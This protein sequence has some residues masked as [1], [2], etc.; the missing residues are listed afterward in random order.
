MIQF[1][2]AKITTGQFAILADRPPQENVDGALEL[3]FKCAPAAK[4]VGVDVS[5]AYES[6]GEKILILKTTCE[7]AIRPEDWDNAVKDGRVVIPKQLLEIFAAQA[8]GTTRGILYC[9]TEGT[10]FNH[11]II[12][13]LNVAR[14]IKSDLEVPVG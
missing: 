10:P 14:L 3:A 1:R 8:V 2:M 13:P 5:W 7:F 6:E 9:K 11:L 4:R 12:P